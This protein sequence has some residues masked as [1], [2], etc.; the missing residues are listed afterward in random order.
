MKAIRLVSTPA[1]HTPG[2]FRWV[3]EAVRPFDIPKACE[4]FAA[5]GLPQ[6]IAAKVANADPGTAW[7]IDD[8]A[9]TVTVT[10]QPDESPTL[11]IFRRFPTSQGGEIIALFPEL[12]GTNS[13][14]TCSSYMHTGQH[15]AATSDL[16]R[17]TRPASPEE[18]AAL[19]CELE[20][21]TPT[22]YTLKTVKRFTRA[23]YETRKAALAAVK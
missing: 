23:H 9:G 12:P 8:D 20:S 14:A 6:E 10:V 11:V 1:V 15:G 22:P 19:K 21:L 3:V 17:S 2:V 7:T 18:F 16:V 5:L 4:L 13:P